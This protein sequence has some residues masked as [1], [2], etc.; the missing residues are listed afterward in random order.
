MP[1]NVFTPILA[2]LALISF[3]GVIWYS[4]SDVQKNVA[5]VAPAEFGEGDVTTRVPPAGWKE[6]KNM[7]YGLPFFYPEG[8]A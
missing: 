4:I 1:K 2:V 5:S 8:L 7:T 3:V 6:Y